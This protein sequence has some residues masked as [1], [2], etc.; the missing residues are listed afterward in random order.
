MSFETDEDRMIY[1]LSVHRDLIGWVIKKLKEEGIPAERTTGND[2]KGDIFL[3]RSE[4]ASRV[5][6]IIR[7][8]QNKYN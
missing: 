7:E 4:D 6:E 8:M 5:Q 3:I 2:R 1:N